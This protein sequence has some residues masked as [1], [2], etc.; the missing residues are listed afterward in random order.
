MT[1]RNQIQKLLAIG[2]LMAADIAGTGLARGQLE[3]QGPIH[4]WRLH[5]I[6]VNPEGKPLENV[7]VTLLRDGA[8]AYRTRTDGSGRF[9]FDHIYGRYWLHIDKANYSQLNRE[10]SV[11]MR[12]QGVLAPKTLFV[13]AGPQACADDCSSVFTS[14]SEFERKIHRNTAHPY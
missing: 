6:F 1:R 4:V 12:V 13:V 5:G 3:E 11:A 14:K 9:A 8:V 10:V 2:V 7:E